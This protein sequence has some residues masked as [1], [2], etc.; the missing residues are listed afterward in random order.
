LVIPAREVTDTNADKLVARLL[1]QRTGLRTVEFWRRRVALWLRMP[2]TAPLFLIVLDGLNENWNFEAWDQLVA[3]FSAEPWQGRAAVV[4]SCRPD[5]WKARL[6]GFPRLQPRARE[7]AILP[8]N[9]GE[10][11]AVLRLHG[12]MRDDL[13][14][15]ILPLLRVPRLCDLAMRH[16]EVLGESG[17]VTPEHLVY[18]DWKDTC[19]DAE[20]I[21]TYG[22]RY[23]KSCFVLAARR[24]APP[25]HH[26]VITVAR[27]DARE[28]IAAI[29]A[30]LA[31]E[32]G[33]RLRTLRRVACRT[34][35]PM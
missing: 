23:C 19:G 6:L 24:T 3:R 4:M 33:D 15:A 8:F 17:D 18:E 1:A 28:G 21:Y 34:G 10:L 26:V 14:P 2:A 35:Q 20:P 29:G 30:R 5:H 12:K 16:A 32:S 11:E 22:S 27:H 31:C 25:C 9:D 7:V 13:P